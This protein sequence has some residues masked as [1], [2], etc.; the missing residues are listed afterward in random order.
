ME[1]IIIY[2]DPM[3]DEIGEEWLK[4][5]DNYYKQWKAERQAGG[6]HDPK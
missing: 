3:L 6:E 5:V 1:R 2:H 4:A